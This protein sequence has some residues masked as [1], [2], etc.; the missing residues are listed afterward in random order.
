MKYIL[1]NDLEHF[2]FTDSVFDGVDKTAD[3]ITVYLENVKI[4]ADN[5]HNRDIAV[6][7]TNDF[8]FKIERVTEWSLIEEG[9]QLYD[10]DMRPYRKEEDRV[11]APENIDEDLSLMAGCYVDEVSASEGRYIFVFN[12][13]DHTYRLEVLGQGSSQNWE[14]FLSV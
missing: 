11:V 7:R 8:C 1:E 2:D 5:P 12:V 3:G 13:G 9:Y 14:H 10:A 6:K 4:T